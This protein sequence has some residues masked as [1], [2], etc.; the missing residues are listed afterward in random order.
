M[1]VWQIGG[2]WEAR[3]EKLTDS[4]RAPRDEPYK[5]TVHGSAIVFD[6]R[7]EKVAASMG[8]SN[9]LEDVKGRNKQK[10]KALALEMEQASF[11]PRSATSSLSS[12]ESRSKVLFL[13]DL[14]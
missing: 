12:V 4:R 11:G 10:H 9:A 5:R 6:E 2:A 13:G 7:G 14:V 3:N 8:I 1:A